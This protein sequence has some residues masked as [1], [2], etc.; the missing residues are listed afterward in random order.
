MQAEQVPHHTTGGSSLLQLLRCTSLTFGTPTPF[1]LHT[2]PWPGIALAQTH[3]RPSKVLKCTHCPIYSGPG[4]ST[5][6][7]LP[8]AV[9]GQFLSERLQV[10]TK[11]SPRSSFQTLLFTEPAPHSPPPPPPPPGR[12][13]TSAEAECILS[14]PHLPQLLKLVDL[15][16]SNLPG[17]QLLLL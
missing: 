13:E 14:R 17:P 11:E 8:T 16:G 2:H 7:R 6:V 9:Q 5:H 1:L 15:L 10:E 4:S 3:Q 12:Q